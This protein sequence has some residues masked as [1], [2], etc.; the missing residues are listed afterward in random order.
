MDPKLMFVLV[1]LMTVLVCL[2][3]DADRGISF[4][5]N[6]INIISGCEEQSI[7]IFEVIALVLTVK[8]Q[9]A[10]CKKWKDSRNEPVTDCIH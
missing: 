9:T 1:A 10:I 3:A 7:P 4:A 5:S 8:E 6:C 2:S